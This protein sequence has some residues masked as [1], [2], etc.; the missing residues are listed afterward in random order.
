MPPMSTLYLSAFVVL[1]LL[2]CCVKFYFHRLNKRID[3]LNTELDLLE[4]GKH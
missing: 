4:A 1:C 3:R 2:L